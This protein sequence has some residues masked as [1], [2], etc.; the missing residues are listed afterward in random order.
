MRKQQFGWLIFT[1]A[2]I[3]PVFCQ[4]SAG[5]SD[6]TGI[7]SS[8]NSVSIDLKD[9]DVRSALEILFK[10]TGKNFTIDQDV[11]GVIPSISF[12]DV[13]FD[14]ALKN[15]ARTSGLTYRIDK[16][17]Y[18]ISK[19]QEAATPAVDPNTIPQSAI[20]DEPETQDSEIEKIQLNFSSATDVLNAMNGNTNNNSNGYGSYGSMFGLSGSGFGNNSFGNSSF[21]NNSFGSNSFG[22]SFGNSSFG[23]SG[24]GSS[25]GRSW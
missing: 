1:L 3:I 16:D 20:Q 11:S 10:N 9:V 23:S 2:A 7:S 4:V 15:I 25:F 17:I 8:N 13:P 12:K 21:G 14:L 5:A 18:L 24:F 22:N 19:R 6:E